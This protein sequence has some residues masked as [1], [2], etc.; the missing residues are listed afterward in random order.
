VAVPPPDRPLSAIPSSRAR[1]LAFLAIL[2][3]GAAGALIGWSFVDLQCHG[4]CTGPSGIG[5]VVG[6]TSAAG[7]V[8]VVAVLTLRAMGEWRTIRAQ[9]ELERFLAERDEETEESPDEG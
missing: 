1:L 7:G 3:A 8:A 2:L 9:Q 5:A 4:N 6:G